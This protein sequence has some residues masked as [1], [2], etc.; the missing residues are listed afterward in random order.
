MVIRTNLSPDRRE[1]AEMKRKE[2][3]RL[4][5][6]WKETHVCSSPLSVPMERHALAEWQQKADGSQQYFSQQ[7]MQKTA[8]TNRQHWQDNSIN[9]IKP[10]PPDQR[11]Q[12]VVLPQPPINHQN[13]QNCV[14]S[15]HP[16]TLWC[17]WDLLSGKADF[18]IHQQIIIFLLQATKT[19]VSSWCLLPFIWR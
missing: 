17:A 5:Q 3:L 19:S 13:L 1:E 12:V 18:K 14:I 7:Y 2:Q 15:L 10:Y 11:K 4:S 16:R 9:R 6:K 8:I